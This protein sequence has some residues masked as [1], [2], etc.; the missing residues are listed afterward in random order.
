VT[1]RR[2]AIFTADD[3]GY[4]RGINRGIVMAH[5]QGVVTATSLMV[6]APAAREAVAMAA[7]HPALAVGMHV[8][9]TNEAERLCAFEDAAVARQE[10]RRQYD[11]FLE[12]VGRPPAHLDSHQHVHRLPSCVP[13]FEELAAETG[14]HLRDRPPVTYKGGFYAQWDYGVSD[15]TKVSFEALTGI[16][17]RELTEGI[18]EFCVHP[19][20]FDPDF[21]A[22]YHEDREQELQTLCDPR[23]KDFLKDEGVRLISF[24]GL[25]E[26]VEV[27]SGRA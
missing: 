6:N 7:D 10:L 24:Q 22:V 8:N 3:F 17:G 12:L 15:P 11:H 25:A 23:L 13:A 26:A 21:K 5:E 2:F 19:G 16:I 1:E 18:Y 27:L 20:F 14:L 9:F 4:S